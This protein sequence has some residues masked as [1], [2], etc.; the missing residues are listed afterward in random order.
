MTNPEALGEEATVSVQ[1]IN[2]RGQ[3]LASL[4]TTG[5]TSLLLNFS[6]LSASD[7]GSYRC[8]ALIMSPVLDGPQTFER[9]FDL[10]PVGMFLLNLEL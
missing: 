6:Q 8:R 4:N 1:W 10:R 9:V 5:N 2:S 3:V 7:A